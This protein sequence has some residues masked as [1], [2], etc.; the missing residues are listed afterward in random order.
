MWPLGACLSSLVFVVVPLFQ[1]QLLSPSVRC[2]FTRSSTSF[3]AKC[4][5]VCTHLMKCKLGTRKA[6]RQTL[7]TMFD[8]CCF[9]LAN[10]SFSWSLN[11]CSSILFLR[12]AVAGNSSFKWPLS[13]LTVSAMVGFLCSSVLQ[14]HHLQTSRHLPPTQ[15]CLIPDT[16]LTTGVNLDSMEAHTPGSSYR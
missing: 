10:V 9:P 1:D 12:G 4:H 8:Y 2:F 14:H 13:T 16:S 3:R 6:T 15:N 5:R 11:D 7:K